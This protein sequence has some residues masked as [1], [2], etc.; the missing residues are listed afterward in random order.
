MKWVNEDWLLGKKDELVGNLPA[1]F[2]D[3][4]GDSTDELDLVY[5]EGPPEPKEP[6]PPLQPD[7]VSLSTHAFLFLHVLNFPNVY[8]R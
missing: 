8:P 5:T 2:V 6:P 1:N 3:F 4:M 7:V